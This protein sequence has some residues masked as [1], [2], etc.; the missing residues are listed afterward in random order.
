MILSSG[1]YDEPIPHLVFSVELQLN[2]TVI[3]KKDKHSCGI[4]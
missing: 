1:V 3:K 4:K 2:I